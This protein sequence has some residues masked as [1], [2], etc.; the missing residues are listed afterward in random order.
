MKMTPQT[1]T[2]QELLE[3]RVNNMLAVNPEYQRGA[4]WSVGQKK[5]LIDSVLRGYPIPLSPSPT[6]PRRASPR[7]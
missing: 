1:K 7:S 2:V 5:K 6:K 3:L 4:V